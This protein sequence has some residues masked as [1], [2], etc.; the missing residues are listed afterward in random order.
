MDQQLQEARGKGQA[1]H[2]ARTGP[3]TTA[4]GTYSAESL[5]VSK[6]PECSPNRRKL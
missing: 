6:G 2:S 3:G 5:I 1:L 4:V